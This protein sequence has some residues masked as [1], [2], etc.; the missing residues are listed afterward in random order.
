M[1]HLKQGNAAFRYSVSSRGFLYHLQAFE[2]NLT[3]DLF[4]LGLSEDL[5]VHDGGCGDA[6]CHRIDLEEPAHS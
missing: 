2:S 6:S 5:S 3:S 1:E 4:L